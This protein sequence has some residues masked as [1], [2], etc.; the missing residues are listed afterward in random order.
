MLDAPS[1]PSP[2][3]VLVAGS[4][5]A[6]SS[7]PPAVTT[8]AAARGALAR[9]PQARSI[10]RVRRASRGPAGADGAGG[11]AGRGGGR[12]LGRAGEGR[13]EAPGAVRAAGPG[14]HRRH[15]AP[16]LQPGAGGAD[17]PAWP[18]SAP[19]CVSFLWERPRAASAARS[20]S[21]SSTTSIAGIE[22]TRASSTCPRPASWMTE[23]P[24][25]A[26]PKAEKVYARAVL[27]GMK[28]GINTLYQKCPHLGCRVPHCVTSQW[29][30]CPCHGSQ[31]NRVGEKRGG[32]APR[33]M[34]R[35]AVD[36][37]RRRGHRS[38]P[39]PSSWG[40]PSAPT[41]PARRPRVRT[42]SRAGSDGLMFAVATWGFAL[43]LG[44]VLLIAWV[45][46]VAINVF[47]KRARQEVGA[48]LELAPNRKPYYDD[49]VARGPAAG[50]VPAL[51]P[52]DAG[53][54][55]ARPPALL[56]VRAQPPGRRRGAGRG[57]A[58]QV[59]RG[60][61]RDRRP[62]AGSTAPAATAA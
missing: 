61:V 29:F 55:R 13:A 47:G 11:R 7:S 43:V 60:A 53:R 58:G 57:H 15:P 26:L 18:A 31:Y 3:V 50:A 59:G 37:Q 44:V 62:R 4:R 23:Y 16:V 17:R 52:A 14:D 1:S 42:A 51:R 34:D 20:T 49:E 24:A 38:T 21:A 5:S 45:V 41:P 30:E 35:F 10:R 46:Y 9:D 48:E 36:H 8:R 6:C 56:A 22:Q 32:P 25:E 19:P 33:G 39:A 54:H 12:A 27:V 28:A 40:P 2:S